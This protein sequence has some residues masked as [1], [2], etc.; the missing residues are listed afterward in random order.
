M[1]QN[2]FLLA[3]ELILWFGLCLN[4]KNIVGHPSYWFEDGMFCCFITL[5]LTWGRPNA[6]DRKGV[7]CCPFR[8]LWCQR[9]GGQTAPGEVTGPAG[10]AGPGGCRLPAPSRQGRRQPLQA[11]RPAVCPDSYCSF[12]KRWLCGVKRICWQEGELLLHKF[13]FKE[14]IKRVNEK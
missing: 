9:P 1:R 14:K 6:R 10:G 7:P 2:A 8:N 13:A 12:M 3:S 4:N 11:V 5:L